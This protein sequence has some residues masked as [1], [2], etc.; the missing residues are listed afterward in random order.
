MAR[1]AAVVAMAVM[2]VAI[3]ADV[4]FIETKDGRVSGIVEESL[5]GRDFF[6][7]YGIPYAQPPLGKLRFKDPEPFLNWA[8]IGEASIPA[9]PCIQFSSAAKKIGKNEVLGTEDCLY[10]NVFTPKVKENANLPV[11]VWLHGG[12]FYRSSAEEFLPHVLLD[13]DVVLVVVQYRLGVLGF[14]ST[15]DSVMPGNLGLKDQTMALQWVKRNIQ[16]FGGDNTRVTIF[17]ESAGGASVHFQML[18]TRAKGLFSR[19]I[20]QSGTALC[21]WALNNSPRKEALQVGSTL[22]C[23]TDQSSEALLLCLQGLDAKALF[24]LNEDF[25]KWFTL[26]LTFTPWVDGHYLPDHPAQLMRDGRLAEV[27]IISGITRDDGAFFALPALAEKHLLEELQHNFSVAGPASLELVGRSEDPVGVARQLYHHYLGTTHVTEAHA[28]NFMRMLTDSHFAVCHDLTTARHAQA[29]HPTGRTF[30]YELQH[31][32]QLSLSQLLCPS[33]DKKWVSHVDDLYYLF[34]G[35]PLLTPPTAPQ[36]RPKDLQR[37]D[38][39]ALRDIITTLWTNFAATGNPTPDASLGFTWEPSTA[40]NLQYLSLT[41][42]PSMQPDNRKETRR[43]HNSLPLQ[44]NLILHPHLVEGGP[45]AP[46]DATRSL[47][48]EL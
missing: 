8:D 45:D 38:D 2:V 47:K 25:R 20:L 27:D 19:S 44:E 33:C 39:L 21:P 35:G 30:R 46:E 14:L 7:F 13:H 41:L 23:P 10:L 3:A 15:E 18:T 31:Y 16:L 29:V 22:G 42:T 24:P 48:T 28:E 1:S 36:D 11:M 6:S 26:P 12:G 34:R 9:A 32:A 5:K 43:F 17:G 37:P 40:D 4:P